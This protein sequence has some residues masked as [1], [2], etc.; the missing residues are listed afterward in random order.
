MFANREEA[1]VRLAK[2]LKAYAGPNTVVL[3]IPRG[4][5][6]VGF[7]VAQQLG[8]PFD[9]VLTKKIGHPLNHE[10]AIGAVGLEDSYIIPHDEVSAEYLAAAKEKVRRRLRDMQALYKQGRLMLP[11]GGKTVI[12]VDDGIATGNTLLV[13]I[14]MLRKSDPARIIV[15]APVSSRQ[16][17]EKLQQEADDCV[18]LLVPSLFTGVGAYYDDFSEVTDETVIAI[19]QQA[20]SFTN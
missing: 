3:G 10:Y 9:L 7:A 2:E 4:G 14:R 17:L 20:D 19:M 8:V 6:P 11:I 15:A 5:V 13:T 12:V 1:A 18:C 16:A